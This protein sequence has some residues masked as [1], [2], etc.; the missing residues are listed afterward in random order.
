MFSFHFDFLLVVLF[1]IQSENYYEARKSRFDNRV[2]TILSRS[3]FFLIIR[4]HWRLNL[5]DRFIV[6]YCCLLLLTESSEPANS[7]SSLYE[8]MVWVNGVS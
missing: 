5:C 6:V 7:A 8:L 2:I 4:L 1:D 3:C